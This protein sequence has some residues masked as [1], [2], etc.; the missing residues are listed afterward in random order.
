MRFL[1]Q[2]VEDLT[3][4]HRLRIIASEEIVVRAAIRVG[5]HQYRARWQTVA[6]RAAD[7]LVV[8]LHAPWQSGMNHSPDV[9]FVDAHAEGDRRDDHLQLVRQELRLHA[10][11]H[12]GGEPGMIR[13]GGHV[14]LQFRCQF[15]GGGPGGRVDDGGPP[16]VVFQQLPHQREAFVLGGLYYFD[17]DVVAAKA[18]DE[19]AIAAES[20]LRRDI[21]LHQRRGSGRQCDH[22]RRAQSRQMLAQRPV[23][24]AEIVPPL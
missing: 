12:S 11:P 1:R 2:S 16:S 4:C 22:R 18:M 13:S 20:K 9:R 10:L 3:E 23:I 15:I 5:V 21:V 7:L 6:A 19:A 14:R 17:G 24:G 8:G